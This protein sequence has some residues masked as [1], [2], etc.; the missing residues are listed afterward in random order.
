VLVVFILMVSCLELDL[1]Q[2]LPC[3]G[4]LVPQQVEPFNL[5]PWNSPR[6]E[7]LGDELQ[8]K[9]LG[10]GILYPLKTLA[11]ILVTLNSAAFNPLQV[12]AHF[13]RATSRHSTLSSPY[14]KGSAFRRLV[15]MAT[16]GFLDR[17]SLLAQAATVGP[18]LFAATLAPGAAQAMTKDAEW[19]LWP[20]FPVAPYSKR[21]TIRRDAGPGV[22]MFEQIF[23]FGY[24]YVPIRMTVI[25]MEAGGLFVYAPV[26]PTAECLALLQPLID[27]FGPIRYIVLPSAAV[28]HKVVAGPFAYNFPSAEFYV[29][30]KQFSFPVD[31]PPALLTFPKWTKQLPPSSQTLAMWGGE[32]D[33]EVL[34]TQPQE[35]SLLSV[36]SFQEAAF[37]HKPTKTLLLCDSVQSISSE[38]PS[39]L[40]S[41]PEYIRALLFHARDDP[42]ELVVDSPAVRQKGW[43]RIAL[44]ANFVFPGTGIFNFKFYPET[45]MPELGWGG[46][47]PF[48]WK[49]SWTQS[50]E[51]LSDKGKPTVSP[52]V[53]IPISLGEETTERWVDSVTQWNFERVVPAH[54]DAPLAIGPTEFAKVF[55]FI[56]NRRNTVR[57]CDEDVTW[58]REVFDSL[59]PSIIALDSLNRTKFGPLRG[60]PCGIK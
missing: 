18:G 14:T 1:G 7:L 54:F 46:A 38:P 15:S 20:V 31:L 40:V 32:F 56:R 22:W 25:A 17:R 44:L 21:K 60:P 43:Q 8:R 26:A 41:E 53:Q 49:P 55:D 47:S 39:I 12:G 5:Q 51:A 36:A 37:F 3:P 6:R 23:G 33:H 10:P 27:Q 58:L 52:I 57:F 24:I 11:M 13:R 28:E 29:T 59:P 9:L 34:T 48:T 42:L 4:S 2:H 45:P 35:P 30:D 16:A 19:P 50:F